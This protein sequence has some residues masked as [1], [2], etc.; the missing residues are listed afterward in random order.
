MTP[1]RGVLAS[2]R[3]TDFLPENHDARHYIE[4]LE[5]EVER[6]REELALRDDSLA[7]RRA[8][9]LTEGLRRIAENEMVV[10]ELA[11]SIARRY[12][13]G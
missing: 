13:N 11:K 9:W 8:R 6:L 3:V 10:S 5:T 2:Y 4:R 7:N 12:L 1:E